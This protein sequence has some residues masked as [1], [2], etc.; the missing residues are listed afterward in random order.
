MRIELK[1]IERN[2]SNDVVSKKYVKCNILAPVDGDVCK[3]Y[4]ALTL[5]LSSSM[6]GKRLELAKKSL[7]ATLEQLNERDY[8]C[9][10]GYH[11]H[12]FVIHPLCSASETN[13][14]V[15]KMAID[16]QRTQ[17]GTNIYSGW[18][19]ATKMLETIVDKHCFKQ[20][21]LFTDGCAG[22][23]PKTIQGFL[24][25]CKYSTSQMIYT[26]TLGLGEYCNHV[27]L[28]ELADHCG[29]KCF[30]VR[31][32]EMLEEVFLRELRDNQDVLYPKVTLVCRASQNL[33]I[34][35]LGPQPSYKVL[36]KFHIELFSQ[37]AGQ[38]NEL[39]LVLSINPSTDE[40]PY[41]EIT[42]VDQFL[43]AVGDSQILTFTPE[44]STPDLEIANYACQFVI[45]LGAVRLYE[46]RNSPKKQKK[47][48]KK[49][50]EMLEGIGEQELWERGFT[51]LCV[52]Y[53]HHLPEADRLEFYNDSSLV[54]RTQEATGVTIRT[55]TP[56][57]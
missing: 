57:R 16:I 30:Y 33:K 8:F 1:P 46:Y 9:I 27:F 21:I 11:K 3:L 5:D 35:N 20:C 52:R 56:K 14:Q 32:Q 38:V 23:G 24:D 49:L 34:L 48:I 2:Y 50:Q 4:L 26:S 7:L 28:R 55:N 31:S 54:I 41:L 44:K 19:T 29:G 13:K 10:V 43:H 12:S 39:L 6:A 25:D 53:R 42:P 47:T 22:I 36:N 37:R 40:N 51:D 15:A 18:L 17:V 45:A